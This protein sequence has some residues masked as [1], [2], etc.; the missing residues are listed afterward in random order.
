LPGLAARAVVDLRAAVADLA[1]SVGGAEV[2]GPLGWPHV[3]PDL[4][5]RPWR[6]VFVT[7]EGGHRT[8]HLHLMTLDAARRHAPLLFRDALRADPEHH[9]DREAS[10][11]AE[12]AFVRR[13]RDCDA[14]ACHFQRKWTKTRPKFLESFSTRS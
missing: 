3:P 14:V 6:R 10:A 9:G 5:A 2:L 4:D 7:V 11:G 12:A 13:W 8:A 1:R